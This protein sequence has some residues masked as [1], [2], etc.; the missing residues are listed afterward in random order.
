MN[1]DTTINLFVNSEMIRNRQKAEINMDLM[2]SAG[3]KIVD[4][5]REITG[6]GQNISSR[7]DKKYSESK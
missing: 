6:A 3:S 4:E 5:V 1:Y 2:N 7:D